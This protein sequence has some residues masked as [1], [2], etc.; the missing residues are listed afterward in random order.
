MSAVTIELPRAGITLLPPWP[1]YVLV[2]ARR[3]GEAPADPWAVAGQSGLILGRVWMV[4]PVPISG[5]RGFCAIGACLSCGHIGSIENKD[6][7]LSCRRCKIVTPRCSLGR[8]DLAVL[9]IFD[10]NGDPE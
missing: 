6:Q 9:K 1:A 7:P 10:A 8:P 3:N 2:D 5:G 4:T